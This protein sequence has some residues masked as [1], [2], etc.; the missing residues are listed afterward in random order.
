MSN[1]NT[2]HVD[3]LET[4]DEHTLEQEQRSCRELPADQ[5][6]EELMLQRRDRH[7]KN[8]AHI[9]FKKDNID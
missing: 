4:C 7:V 1:I 9:I 2:S 5:D 8:Q 3:L 6:S